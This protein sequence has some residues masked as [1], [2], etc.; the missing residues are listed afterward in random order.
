MTNDDVDR[1][2]YRG[3]YGIV[4]MAVYRAVP[5][6]MAVALD[7]AVDWN[8]DRSVARSVDQALHEDALHPGLELY[9]KEVA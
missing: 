9:S 3:G 5:L 4:G 8:V 7:R 1:A 2:V 6:T